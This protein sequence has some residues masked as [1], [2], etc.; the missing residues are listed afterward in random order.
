MRR[1]HR[2]RHRPQKQQHRHKHID[3]GTHGHLGTHHTAKVKDASRATTHGLPFPPVEAGEQKHLCSRWTGQHRH[4]LKQKLRARHN[5]ACIRP[6][7]LASLHT[8]GMEARGRRLV[9]VLAATCHT[10]SMGRMG[11]RGKCHAE[12]HQLL[13]SCAQYDRSQPSVAEPHTPHHRQHQPA[14]Y[15]QL[16]NPSAVVTYLMLSR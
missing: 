12:L 15:L 6:A 4:P 9:D 2:H 16:F 7:C 13:Q 14:R 11:T 5:A 1:T 10:P 8:K 3:V